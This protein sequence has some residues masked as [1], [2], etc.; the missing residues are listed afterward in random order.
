M[1]SVDPKELYPIVD[2]FN[3]SQFILRKAVREGNFILVGYYRREVNRLRNLALK[4]YNIIL[5]DL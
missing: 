3:R 5:D 1:V 2:E 4:K